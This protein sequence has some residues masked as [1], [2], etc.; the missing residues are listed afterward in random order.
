MRVSPSRMFAGVNPISV[1]S[2]AYS[3]RPVSE[4]T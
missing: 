2:A 3:P 1:P 4:P